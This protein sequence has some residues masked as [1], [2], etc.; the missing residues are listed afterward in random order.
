VLFL[1]RNRIMLYKQQVSITAYI[2]CKILQ[3]GDYLE[4][5]KVDYILYTKGNTHGG[6]VEK[7]L[8]FRYMALPNINFK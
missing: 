2:D 8:R 5:K 3:K 4:K 7:L 6:K 1:Y